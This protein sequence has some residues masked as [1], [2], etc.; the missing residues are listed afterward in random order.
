M[1]R[2][3]NRPNQRLEDSDKNPRLVGER[4]SRLGAATWVGAV[5]NSEKGP[6]RVV[7]SARHVPND[8]LGHFESFNS[9]HSA[10]VYFLK[11]DGAV[12]LI[13]FDI[14]KSLFQTLA[15]RNGHLPDDDGPE[16]DD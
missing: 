7:G 4:S 16:D 15:T 13:S 3:L 11:G 12:K 1:L 5:P 8:V 6:K 2:E 10:G 14:D 9:I